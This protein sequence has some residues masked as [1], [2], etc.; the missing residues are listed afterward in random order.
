MDDFTLILYIS[1]GTAAFFIILLIGILVYQ[2]WSNCISGEGSFVGT[3]I[4][5]FT[6]QTGS[7]G[8]SVHNGQ[9]SFSGYV[10]TNFFLTFKTDDNKRKMLSCKQETYERLNTIS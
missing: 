2:I 8:G 10:K 7:S 6:T 9:G 1:C 5:K 3:C 4:D